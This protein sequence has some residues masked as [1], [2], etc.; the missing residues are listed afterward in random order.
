MDTLGQPKDVQAYSAC[1]EWLRRASSDSKEC[2]AFL[3]SSELSEEAFLRFVSREYS[4][5]YIN[6]DEVS[7]DSEFIS[8]FP[9][10]ILLD[11][12]IVPIHQKDETI[13][14]VVSNPF[15]STGIDELRKN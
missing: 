14:A 8:H 1:I 12:Q 15:T 3:A 6:L 7:V 4:Y 9:A 11:R 10:R 5:P 13:L 2:P